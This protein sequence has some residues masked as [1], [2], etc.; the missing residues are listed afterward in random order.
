MSKNKEC[1]I[2][3]MLSV[4]CAFT[5]LCVATTSSPLYVTNFW[6]DT[7]IFLTMGR[8]I[9]QGMVP[10]RDLVDQKGPLIFL[11]YAL[12]AFITDSSFFGAFL[13]ECISMS[14]FLF[15]AWKTV[16]LYGKGSLTYAVIPLTAMI[17]VC[18]TAFTQGGSAEEFM[19]PALCFAM[20]VTLR[21]MKEGGMMRCASRRMHVGF[22][23]SMGWVFS[24]K[25]TDCGLFFG[26]GACLV[27][28]II[29]NEGFKGTVRAVAEM[30]LGFCIVVVPIAVYLAANGALGACLDIYFIQNMFVYSGKRMTFVEHI[31]N[32][33]A[34]LRTQSIANPAVAG[35]AIWGV[36][37]VSIRALWMKGRGWLIHA[38]AIPIGAGLLLLFCYWGEMAHP[39][40]ALAFAALVPLGCTSFGWI[41]A[42]ADQYT[43][44]AGILL[45]AVSVAMTAIL[46]QQLC[47]A[48]PLQKVKREEMPQTILA[49]IILKEENP[50]LLDISSLDHGFYLA[51]GILPSCRYFCELNVDSQQKRESIQRDLIQGTT[52]FVVSRYTNPGEKYELIAQASGVFDLNA[53]QTYFLYKRIEE[54][55]D[56]SDY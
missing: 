18:S 15:V 33:L 31:Y 54:S 11:I 36:I 51:A 5:V 43:H 41:A 17:T 42:K 40:Y 25:Y 47:L 19:L 24:I 26:L 9:A 10:Y 30:F 48:V 29:W 55:A 35:L 13:L 53:L 16:L 49:E 37:S 2:A 6:T 4:F 39:Y 56:G 27:L 7:N 14:I 21:R 3:V 12:A 46:P 8:G 22:G 52:Q 45:T 28:W 32:A 44:K 34:Y 38:F 1:I 50:T 20:Y 23:V